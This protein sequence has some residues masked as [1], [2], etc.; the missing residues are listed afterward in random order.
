MGV[1]WLFVTFYLG[2]ALALDSVISTYSAFGLALIPFV[3]VIYHVS[4]VSP[5]RHLT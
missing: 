3:I 1:V 4:R 2:L 5:M